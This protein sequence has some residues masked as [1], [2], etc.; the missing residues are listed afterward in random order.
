MPRGLV[1]HGRIMPSDVGRI[2]SGIPWF[3]IVRSTE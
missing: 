3:P 2:I 1:H